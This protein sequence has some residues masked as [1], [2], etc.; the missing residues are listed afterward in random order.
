[1]QVILFNA[2]HKL[3]REFSSASLD[4]GRL[5]QS[6]CSHLRSIRLTTS[7]PPSHGESPTKGNRGKIGYVALLIRSGKQ[8]LVAMNTNAADKQLMLR[9]AGRRSIYCVCVNVTYAQTSVALIPVACVR[10]GLHARYCNFI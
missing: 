10:A 1:M 6:R 9:A 5:V 2:R 7:N 8:E 4:T 3:D